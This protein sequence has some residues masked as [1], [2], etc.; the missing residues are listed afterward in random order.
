MNESG[1]RMLD[2]LPAIYRTGGPSGSLQ[3]LLGVFEEVLFASR[4]QDA[5]GIEQ[6]IETIPSFFSPL[7]G[8]HTH[9]TDSADGIH[10][11]KTPDRFL[12]WLATWVAFTP[13][14]LFTPERL[15]TIVAGIA[16]LYGSRGTRSYLEQLLKLCF[17]E[18]LEVEIDDDPISGFVIGQAKLGEDTLFG[19]ER[20]F[21]FRVDIDASGGSFGPKAAESKNEFEQRVRTII[22]F[23]KPAHTEY[24]LR[25]NFSTRDRGGRYTV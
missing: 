4:T 17:P 21:W 11:T 12:S 18:I 3:R 20:P 23:G 22:D 19:D 6:Q 1:T 9:G 15:R 24:E 7:G 14:A 13:H 8:P 16:P 10:A 5:P 25:L 2:S